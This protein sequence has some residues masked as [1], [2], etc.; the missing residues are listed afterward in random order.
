MKRTRENNPS[1]ENLIESLNLRVKVLH[2]GGLET[3]KELA[4][5]CQIRSECRVLDV[6]SGT[7]ETLCFLSETFQCKAVGVDASK[8]PEESSRQELLAHRYQ[9][10][11]RRGCGTPSKNA[12]RAPLSRS[13]KGH[14]PAR[15]G[16]SAVSIVPHT[17]GDAHAERRLG[18]RCR[19]K[20]RPLS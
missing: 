3:T 20:E 10:A 4:G 11:V 8:L 13:H 7:G 6:A 14:E 5:L 1:L 16:T 2:P 9:N 19:R 18:R 17:T 12:P 15:S